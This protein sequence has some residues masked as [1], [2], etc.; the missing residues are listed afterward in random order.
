MLGMELGTRTMNSNQ[1]IIGP[2]PIVSVA[3]N[4][5]H[6]L[7]SV[8]SSFQGENS[9]DKSEDNVDSFQASSKKPVEEE[10]LEGGAKCIEEMLSEAQTTRNLLTTHGDDDGFSNKAGKTSKQIA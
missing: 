9:F 10:Y 5:Q 1:S 2:T 4:L 6:E 8:K 7:S 3:Q